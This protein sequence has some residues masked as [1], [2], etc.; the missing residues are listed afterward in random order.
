M[1]GHKLFSTRIK[2]LKSSPIREILNVIDRDEMISF[3]GG[4]PAPESFPDLTQPVPKKY[5]QY[6]P[7]EG[8]ME[9]RLRIS[10][11]LLDRGLECPAEQ[12]LILSG[13]QQGID[14]T[15]KL[16]IDPGSTVAV[17]SPTYLAALQVYQF[18]G[19]QL[20]ELSNNELT[21]KTAL[22]YV[23][24]TFQNPTGYCYSHAERSQMARRCDDNLTPLFEDDPYYDLAY[25]NVC[26]VPICSM[27]KQAPWIYQSSFSKSF[28]PGLRLGFI[29]CSKSLI[30]NLTYLK[31]AADLHSNRVSQYY[32]LQWLNRTGHTE[33]LN[34]LAS[35]YK[36]KR[37]RFS[38]LLNR[39]F[40]DL[41]QW[42]E[43][44]GGLFFWLKLKADSR[45]NT[46]TLLKKAIE[47]NV[48]FM[49]GENF[50]ISQR[51]QDSFIRLNFSNA[52]TEQ[53]EAG[54]KRL[55]RLMK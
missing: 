5:L 54:L 44:S 12:I 45:C 24:P 32:V 25:D 53:A 6:G 11:L 9:L 37:D 34:R 17:E 36:E 26:R 4:L 39:Y 47:N 49:P 23:N 33:Q 51:Q 42:N 18:Y 38:V 35:D 16:F 3:A 21:D 40:K 52:S 48:A 55:A 31:Q 10:E 7:S 14:L 1:P 27:I 15:G 28:A 30:S 43:P 19:A 13:S 50:F 8:E 20:V 46:Q 22:A 2:N 29:A 41:A